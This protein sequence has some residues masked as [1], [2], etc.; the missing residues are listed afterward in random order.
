MA[1]VW[2]EY[3]RIR[4]ERESILEQWT[5][6]LE[7]QTDGDANTFADMLDTMEAAE[8]A[9]TVFTRQRAPCGGCENV[10]C[11]NPQ[12]VELKDFE[13]SLPVERNANV[14]RME[15]IV[16]DEQSIDMDLNQDWRTGTIVVP[17]S[18]SA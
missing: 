17:M 16:T 18:K 8:F 12:L 7:F 11:S 15:D 4:W 2:S 13:S 6:I 9:Y 1:T 14:V 5:L 3:A 10:T